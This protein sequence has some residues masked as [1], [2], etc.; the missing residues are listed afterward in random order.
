MAQYIAKEI[1]CATVYQY[2]PTATKLAITNKKCTIGMPGYNQSYI[3]YFQY[4]LAQLRDVEITKAFLNLYVI[5]GTSVS[6]SSI[7]RT[8]ELVNGFEEETTNFNN[9]P[10]GASEVYEF[11]GKTAG[12]IQVDITPMVR[13]WIAEGINNGIRVYVHSS[14]YGTEMYLGNRYAE[15]PEYASYIEINYIGQQMYKIN[16]TKL[17]AFGDQA[18]RISGTT[19]GLTLD[20]MLTIF[21][22]AGQGG[23]GGSSLVDGHDINFYDETNNMLQTLSVRDGVS[24]AEPIYPAKKWVSQDGDVIIFPYLPIG[25]IDIYANTD[26]LAKALYDFYKI[27]VVTYPYMLL[28]YSADTSK[29]WS[30]IRFAKTVEKANSTSNG[31]TLKNIKYGK[32]GT[33]AGNWNADLNTYVINVQNSITSLSDVESYTYLFQPNYHYVYTNFDILALG[34]KESDVST[35]GYYR[36][37]Q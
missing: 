28:K 1:K 33:K 14:G 16:E 25:S 17:R 8:T 6:A 27:D 9:R 11:T 3:S 36:L 13:K 22:G 5:S 21:E 15:N 30:R 18:R 24:V 34:F 4:D 10:S 2:Q 35:L 20:E 31:I 7:Y 29:G 37:D 32:T 19:D 26:T 12:W 23:S